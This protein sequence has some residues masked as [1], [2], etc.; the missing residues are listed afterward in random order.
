MCAYNGH[1]RVLRRLLQNIGTTDI[2][3]EIDQCDAAG[4]TALHYAA[5]NGRAESIAVLMDFKADP[6]I[7]NTAGFAAL[8]KAVN[9][10]EETAAL[11]LLNRGVN[12]DTRT[13]GEKPNRTILHLAAES[14][15]QKW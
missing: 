5:E 6:T 12:V 3:A 10:N 14:G 15:L 8:H 9:A 2:Q 4:N 1:A 11:A 7:R 13:T